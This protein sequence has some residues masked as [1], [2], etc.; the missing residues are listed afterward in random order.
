MQ[1]MLWFT[2]VKLERKMGKVSLFRVRLDMC[3][4]LSIFW[5]FYCIIKS[6]CR[7]ILTIKT[8]IWM[9]SCVKW[10]TKCLGWWWSCIKLELLQRQTS[11]TEVGLH[12]LKSFVNIRCSTT[13]WSIKSQSTSKTLRMLTLFLNSRR[14]RRD[15]KLLNREKVKRKKVATPQTRTRSAHTMRVSKF[16]FT[17][18]SR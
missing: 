13:A 11:K 4:T 15:I 5:S 3:I 7:P 1:R 18:M 14:A 12:L 17:M 16:S 2:M 9:W 8:D 10:N 6:N